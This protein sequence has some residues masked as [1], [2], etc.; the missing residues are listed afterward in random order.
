M[1]RTLSRCPRIPQRPFAGFRAC[2]P[3]SYAPSGLLAQ[4]RNNLSG[5]HQLVRKGVAQGVSYRQL[6][7]AASLSMRILQKDSALTRD[8]LKERCSETATG[9]ELD[10]LSALWKKGEGPAHTDCK[11]RLFGHS[12]D[13]A[14]VVSGAAPLLP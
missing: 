5:R 1:T 3:V 4:A 14:R 11:L 8:V 13:E 6:T 10:R 12:E 9:Q 2:L 7:V